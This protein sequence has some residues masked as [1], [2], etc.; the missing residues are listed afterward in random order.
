ME[1]EFVKSISLSFQTDVNRDMA[2]IALHGYEEKDLIRT[3]YNYELAGFTVEVTHSSERITQWSDG[4]CRVY[5]S[6]DLKLYKK[7]LTI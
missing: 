2:D 7:R 3:I 6:A 4:T 1:Y 5:T